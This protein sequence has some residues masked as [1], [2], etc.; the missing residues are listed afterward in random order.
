MPGAGCNQYFR[1]ICATIGSPVPL[2][3]EGAAPAPL[4][5]PDPLQGAPAR[6]RTE[7]LGG[8]SPLLSEALV[9]AGAIAIV[10][11]KNLE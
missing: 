8:G 3:L 5:L 7:P 6:A 11:E 4:A 10:V 2:L 9:A 1:L